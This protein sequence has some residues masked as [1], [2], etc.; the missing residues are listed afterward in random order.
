MRVLVR[1]C[2]TVEWLELESGTLSVRRCARDLPMRQ[3]VRGCVRMYVREGGGRGGGV[4][5]CV[6]VRKCAR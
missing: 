6:C 4:N 1:G 3:G 5:E 2:V